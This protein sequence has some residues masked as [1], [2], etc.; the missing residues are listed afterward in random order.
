[1]F[2]LVGPRPINVSGGVWG[3]VSSNGLLAYSFVRGW[4]TVA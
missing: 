4:C 3:F 2:G 1:M